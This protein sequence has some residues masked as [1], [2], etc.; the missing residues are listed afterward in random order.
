MAPV[1]IGASTAL[2]VETFKSHL[3]ENDWCTC[4]AQHVLFC[5]Q[6]WLQAVIDISESLLEVHCKYPVWHVGRHEAIRFL[7]LTGNLNLCFLLIFK[8]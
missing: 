8:V 6:I 4:S 1:C 2:S 3:L 5:Y 7:I